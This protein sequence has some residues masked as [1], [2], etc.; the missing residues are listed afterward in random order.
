M[1]TQTRIKTN[2]PV[3]RRDRSRSGGF[4]LVEV[5]V[6]FTI[7]GVGLL[8][9]AAAQVKAVHG[10]QSGRHLTQ[11]SLVAQTQLET[12]ARSSWT[13][14]AVTAWTAPVTVNSTVVTSGGDAVE[15]AYDVRWQI[16]DVIA[17]E[18]RSV[19]VQVGWSESDGRAR[20]V[21]AS[22]IVF[23]REDL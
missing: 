8:S 23:N 7:L 22:T 15:Q 10:T 4:T 6:A 19:D 16:Q 11:A 17:N 13:D 14:L 3:S 9:I 21:A 12:L 18:T 20:S 2:P 1:M 5:M